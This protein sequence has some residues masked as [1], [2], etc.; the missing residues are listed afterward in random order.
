MLE[1]NKYS[2]EIFAVFVDPVIEPFD[3]GEIEK[4]QY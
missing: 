1:M 2:A 3:M 4:P